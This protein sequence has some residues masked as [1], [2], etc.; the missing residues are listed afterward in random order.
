MDPTFV[1]AIII[2]DCKSDH[3]KYYNRYQCLPRWKYNLLVP[4]LVFSAE[5]YRRQFIHLFI[6]FLYPVIIR[7]YITSALIFAESKIAN[8]AFLLVIT[9]K[10]K[11]NTTT[12]QL[13]PYI[14]RLL[15]MLW[16][17]GVYL[18]KYKNE[19][20]GQ[21]YKSLHRALMRPDISFYYHTL[22]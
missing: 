14:I 17:D 18:S 3:I 10:N 12:K 19:T 6:K 16:H 8:D 5:T 13:N 9:K 22:C 7:S 15:Y 11:E 2:C 20:R 21:D 4:E 1:Y